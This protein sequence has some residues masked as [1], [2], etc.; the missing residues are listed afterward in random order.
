MAGAAVAGAGWGG[1]AVRG[2]RVVRPASEG[3]STGTKGEQEDL[4]N[5]NHVFR[6]LMH[7]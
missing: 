7:S 4:T 3:G 2:W 5:V 6:Q 1:E